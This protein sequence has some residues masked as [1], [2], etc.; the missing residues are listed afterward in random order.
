M[1]FC[2]VPLPKQAT[3]VMR[4]VSNSGQALQHAKEELRADEALIQLALEKSPQDVGVVRSQRDS[5]T[6]QSLRAKLSAPRSQR[7]GCE[8]KCEF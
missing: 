7:Y 2:A 5:N 3:K 1:V 4:A 8:C 6:L